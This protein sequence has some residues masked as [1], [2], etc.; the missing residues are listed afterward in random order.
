MGRTKG[1]YR[2]VAAEPD[3][4]IVVEITPRRP[5]FESGPLWGDFWWASS[6]GDT[7]SSEYF[8][9]PNAPHILN[10][11]HVTLNTV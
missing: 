5:G 2:I 10:L 1:E 6:Y 3:R 4:R 8:D 11:R 7:L 9:F